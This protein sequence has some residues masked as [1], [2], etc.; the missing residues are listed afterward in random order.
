[1][2]ALKCTV[3]NCCKAE[4][5]WMSTSP[6]QLEDGKCKDFPEKC[7]MKNCAQKWKACQDDEKCHSS[8]EFCGKH[9]KNREEYIHCADEEPLLKASLKCTV[10]NCCKVEIGWMSTSPAKL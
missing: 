3:N 1:M 7:A 9:T 4:K 10:N 5:G 6:T 8:M 2:G